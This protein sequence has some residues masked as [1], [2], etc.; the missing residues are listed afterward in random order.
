[1]LTIWTRADPAAW[2]PAPGRAVIFATMRQTPADSDASSHVSGEAGRAGALPWAPTTVVTDVPASD[3]LFGGTGATPDERRTAGRAGRRGGKAD[4]RGGEADRR[5]GGVASD[6]RPAGIFPGLEAGTEDPPDAGGA[7]SRRGAADVRALVRKVD[8]AR[9]AD[10]GRQVERVVGKVRGRPR[11]LLAR[12]RGLVAVAVAALVVGTGTGAALDA[13]VQGGQ[14]EAAVVPVTSP[15]ACAS[16]QVAWSRA[17]QAQVQMDVSDPGSVREG[18]SRAQTALA[19]SEAPAAVAAQWGTVADS[20]AAVV[21][22][23]EGVEEDGLEE[24]VAG[25]L[26]G[27]DTAAMMAASQQVTD[28]LATDCTG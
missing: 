22:A 28:Y 20:V 23:G 26:A 21:A 1:M 7:R 9:V 25:A 15:E 19:A 13:V 16:A 17:A 8:T 27:L 4:R 18:F 14:P 5:G 6:D 24:A 12:K 3:D 2:T 11:G 10:A